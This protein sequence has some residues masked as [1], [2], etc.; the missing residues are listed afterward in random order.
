MSTETPD[1][2]ADDIAR[3]EE[4]RAAQAR[5]F[6]VTNGDYYVAAFQRIGANA[7]FTWTFNLWAGVLGPVWYGM[8]GMWNWGLAFLI[9]ETFAWVQTIRGL[10][11]NLAVGAWE[12]IAQIEGTLD[13][14]RQQLASA[15]EKGSDK[16]DVY[17]RT[18]ES[19]ENAIGGIRLEAQQLEDSGVYIALGGIVALLAVKLVQA[20]L[21]NSLL[22]K[23]VSEWLSNAALSKGMALRHI[24]LS[25]GFS[26]IIV[27]ATVVH[28]SFPGTYAL[29][30]AFPTKDL[31]RLETIKGVEWFF[32]FC[33]RNG[34]VLFDFIT[35][36]IRF[37]LDGLE[38]IFVQTP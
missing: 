1:V 22:E 33:V 11:G 21:A 28:Y 15:I 4:E 23:R 18:V 2:T 26:A 5:E 13:L 6:V 35:A 30:A 3:I 34:E 29:L 25:V 10:F 31:F 12:R 9:V 16:V 14:R 32:D 7:S 17:K 24:A 19:L 8:R 36:G 27:I 38:V 37:V 20:F